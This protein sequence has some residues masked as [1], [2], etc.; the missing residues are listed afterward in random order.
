M[1]QPFEEELVAVI[2]EY[3]SETD[4]AKRKELLFEYNRIWTENLYSVGVFSGRYGLG[5]AKR[6]Q[7]VPQGTPVFLYTWVE[8][9]VMAQQLWTP[10]EEQIDQIRPETVPVGQPEVA[11]GQ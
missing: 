7:N 10:A 9:A 4:P 2:N 8:D 6:F 11:V 1:L 3:N 5:L